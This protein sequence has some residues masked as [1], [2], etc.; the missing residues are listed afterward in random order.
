MPLVDAGAESS[1]PLKAKVD[2]ESTKNQVRI[3]RDKSVVKNWAS[4]LNSLDCVPRSR[5]AESS[6]QDYS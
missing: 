6:Q 3:S 1:S 4:W 5:P 2:T